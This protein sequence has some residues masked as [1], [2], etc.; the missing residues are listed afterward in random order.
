M[1]V[2]MCVSVWVWVCYFN[3]HC[4][5]PLLPPQPLLKANEF[6]AIGVFAGLAGLGVLLVAILPIET[7]GRSMKV[8]LLGYLTS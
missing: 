1:C 5:L 4:P 2:C 3:I 7:K 8:S 6:A